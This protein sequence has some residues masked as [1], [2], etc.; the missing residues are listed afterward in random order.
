MSDH[1]RADLSGNTF[2]R[3]GSV[4]NIHMHKD[5]PIRPGRNYL[6]DRRNRGRGRRVLST[7]R[8]LD[9]TRHIVKVE[10]VAL[11]RLSLLARV[12]CRV[13]N[14]DAG[15]TLE[16]ASR[17]RAAGLRDHHRIPVA[18]ATVSE[19]GRLVPP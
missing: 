13:I 1:A 5:R 15:E 8:Y 6:V 2:A 11:L 12:T 14:P 18:I 16:P 17:P 3:A 4:V 7:Y 10:R 19:I 9:R